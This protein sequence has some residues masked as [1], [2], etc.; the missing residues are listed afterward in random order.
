METPHAPHVPY[1]RAV[2]DYRAVRGFQDLPGLRALH[3]GSWRKDVARACQACRLLLL[4]GQIL[5][6]DRKFV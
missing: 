1:Y 4:F 5:A 3:A 6:L 2:R